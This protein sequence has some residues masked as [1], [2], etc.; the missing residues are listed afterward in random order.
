MIEVVEFFSLSASETEPSFT[1]KHPFLEGVETYRFSAAF[2]DQ[3]CQRFNYKR[4]LASDGLIALDLVDKAFGLIPVD[5]KPNSCGIYSASLNGP[6]LYDAIDSLRELEG[7]EEK[8]S[9]LKKLWPPK[10][11]FRQNGPLRATHYS[12]F[13]KSRGPLVSLVDPINGLVDAM[14]WAIVDLSL[15][16][17]D[18]AI[19][20][21]AFSCDD[22]QNTKWY[23]ERSVKLSESAVCFLLKKNSSLENFELF[24]SFHANHPLT[25]GQCTP[26]FVGHFKRFAGTLK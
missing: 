11:H 18:Y 9:K 24:P 13:S 7:L 25:H 23:S 26:F 2:H 8:I 6:W 17:V 12:L 20:V 21:S 10:Q 22:I 16:K 1:G 4:S 3:L 5:S 19:V 14:N 15:G